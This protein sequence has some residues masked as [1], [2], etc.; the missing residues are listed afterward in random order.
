M[1]YRHVLALKKDPFD[2]LVQYL[3]RF[4]RHVDQGG[5]FVQDDEHVPRVTAPLYDPV[6]V[7]CFHDRLVH[8]A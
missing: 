8:Y 1:A 6:I 4:L 2:V 7:M 3:L 5:A